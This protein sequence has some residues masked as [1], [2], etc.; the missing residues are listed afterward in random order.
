MYELYFHTDTSQ[1][2]FLKVIIF[3]QENGWWID[4][5]MAKKVI[6]P[7]I[8]LFIRDGRYLYPKNVWNRQKVLKSKIHFEGFFLS[9][10]KKL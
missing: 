2:N 3:F 5:P 8:Q 6:L 1:R 9:Q 4:C 10:N 7:T